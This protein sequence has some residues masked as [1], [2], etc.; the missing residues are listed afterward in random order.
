LIS[1]IGPGFP[2]SRYGVGAP[3][4]ARLDRVAGQRRGVVIP[5]PGSSGEGVARLPSPA[6]GVRIYDGGAQILA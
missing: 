6:R 1:W 4:L 3:A 5:D 2:R